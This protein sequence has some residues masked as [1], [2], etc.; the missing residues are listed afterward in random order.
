[1]R[2]I[3]TQ[4]NPTFQIYHKYLV[5]DGAELH[6]VPT[7]ESRQNHLSQYTYNQIKILNDEKNYIYHFIDNDLREL[8]NPNN[9]SYE[10]IGIFKSVPIGYWSF[11]SNVWRFFETAFNSQY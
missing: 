11:L 4:E 3:Q 9:S 10:P 8:N 5:L 2:I 6:S 7:N 1:M